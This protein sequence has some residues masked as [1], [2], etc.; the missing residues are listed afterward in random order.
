MRQDLIPQRFLLLLVALA[1]MLPIGVFVILGLRQL[2]LAMGD[3]PGSVGALRLAVGCGGVWI[4]DLVSLILVVSINAIS[5]SD[6]PPEG[7]N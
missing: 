4:F 3:E 1:L 5:N 7:E 2:L 6:D